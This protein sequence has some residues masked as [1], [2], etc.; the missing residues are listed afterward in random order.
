[1]V[2][3]KLLLETLRS[4]DT[5]VGEWVNVMGYITQRESKPTTSGGQIIH[6]AAVQAIVFWS[7]GS[8]RIEE[9]ESAL[10]G[11]QAESNLP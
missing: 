8:V 6:A 3:V 1:M 7:A 11:I 2:D 10:A 9:Y 5:C 4:S